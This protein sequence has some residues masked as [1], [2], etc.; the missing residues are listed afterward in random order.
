MWSKRARQARARKSLKRGQLRALPVLVALVILAVVGAASF[1]TASVSRFRSNYSRAKPLSY[2][3]LSAVAEEAERE[4]LEASAALSPPAS[5]P[6]PP[7][8]EAA[9]VTLASNGTAAD[10]EADAVVAAGG[11]KGR[12]GGD[13]ASGAGW[14]SRA[15]EKLGFGASTGG[16]QT[17]AQAGAVPETEV[18]S[19][20]PAAASP[21]AAP[22]ADARV[23]ALLDSQLPKKDAQQGASTTGADGATV[24]LDANAELAEKLGAKEKP[25]TLPGA[26]PGT[27]VSLPSGI[28]A[29]VG[30]G[31]N[32]LVLLRDPEAT[33]NGNGAAAGGAGG[34]AGT[35]AVS[36]AGVATGA[37][38]GGA[39][40]NS[41][42]SASSANGTETLSLTASTS[43]VDPQ[44][45]EANLPTS[46]GVADAD[47]A[48]AK[49]GVIPMGNNSV[50]AVVAP[51]DNPGKLLPELEGTV[52]AKDYAADELHGDD[53]E[54]AA[55]MPKEEHAVLAADYQVDE[56]TQEV[57]ML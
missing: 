28:R 16:A 30:P 22:D 24:L 2:T 38:A 21:L 8:P 52:H 51:N 13:G 29:V 27:V 49:V 40:A 10:A 14:L 3:Q 35:A 53:K 12:A 37:A 11:R 39:A 6:P 23:A 15:A 56:S 55:A 45:I 18:V 20:V 25:V 42:A 33:P 43:G 57:P 1:A 46:A 54:K 26:V 41:T 44:V 36:A 34:A 32:K 17:Q 47:A 19:L 9:N 48:A 50:I 4:A 5:T 31:G 7:S